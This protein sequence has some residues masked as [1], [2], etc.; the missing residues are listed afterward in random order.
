MKMVPNPHGGFP[1]ATPEFTP[2]IR[3]PS[4]KEFASE[5]RALCRDVILAFRI[6]PEYIGNG[7]RAIEVIPPERQLTYENNKCKG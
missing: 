3:G 4:D 6:P 1:I 5:L 7:V 2:I